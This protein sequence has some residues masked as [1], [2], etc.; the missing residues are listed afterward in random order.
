MNSLLRLVKVAFSGNKTR[1]QELVDLRKDIHDRLKKLVR[2]TFIYR[3]VIIATNPPAH[4]QAE[5]YFPNTGFLSGAL[6]TDNVLRANTNEN[7]L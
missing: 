7:F 3:I 1:I 5:K 4:Y 6:R 2:N